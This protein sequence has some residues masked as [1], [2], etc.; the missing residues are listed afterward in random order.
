MEQSQEL[1]EKVQPSPSGDRL[2]DSEQGR[3]LPKQAKY[4]SSVS[5]GLL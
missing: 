3:D 5:Y 2:R 4:L 1:P